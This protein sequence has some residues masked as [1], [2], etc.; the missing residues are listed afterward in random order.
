ME[1]SE[2][3]PNDCRVDTL[4][5]ENFL[6]YVGASV[7][8]NDDYGVAMNPLGQDEMMETYSNVNVVPVTYSLVGDNNY[9][10][11]LQEKPRLF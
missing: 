1:Q 3:V 6:S 2:P 8:S 10:V 11:S 5:T 7:Y 4:V 9:Q